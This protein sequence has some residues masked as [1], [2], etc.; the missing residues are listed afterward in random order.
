METTGLEAFKVARLFRFRLGLRLGSR[1]GRYQILEPG[2]PRGGIFPPDIA[3]T[4]DARLDTLDVL[5]GQCS[6][7]LDLDAEHQLFSFAA[8]LDL[9]RSELRF[10]GHEA[11]KSS[12]RAVRI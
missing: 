4:P 1:F 3:N 10:R 12:H 11:D 9:L 5:A 8:R 6:G 7:H 2:R